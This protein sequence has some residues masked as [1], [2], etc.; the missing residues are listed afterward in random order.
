LFYQPRI[1]LGTGKISGV[2]ALIRW[3]HPSKGIIL[4]NDFLPI[5]VECGLLRQ[6]TEWVILNACRQIRSWQHYISKLPVA[7]NIAP[8]YFLAKNFEEYLRTILWETGISSESLELEVTEDI[9]LID[10]LKIIDRLA[11]VKNL[12]VKLSID[13]FGTGY[14]N[15]RFFQEVSVDTFKIDNTFVKNL[16]Q[17]KA[18]RDL[19]RAMIGVGHSMNVNMVAEGIE[20]AEQLGLLKMEGCDEGQGNYFCRPRPAEE[21][22]ALIAKNGNW[23]ESG[24]DLPPGIELI[25]N[26]KQY[27]PHNEQESRQPQT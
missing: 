14:S 23:M 7:V 24:V 27:P 15:L 13:D 17:K 19:V 5:A 26:Y 25:G 9:I 6:I 22:T 18:D 21:L 12:G 3:R 11:R 2:E 8:A 16:A 1:N 10:P 20:D 4:P